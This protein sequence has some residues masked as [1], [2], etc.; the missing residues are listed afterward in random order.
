MVAYLLHYSKGSEFSVA[1][2]YIKHMSKKNRLIVLYGSC[3]GYHRIG[4]TAEMEEFSQKSPL[5]NVSFIPVKPSFKSKNWDY[6]LKGIREFY[7]EYEQW[8]KDLLQVVCQILQ[9]KKVDIIHFLGPIGY[10]EPGYLYD[11]PV[12]YI[13]G[14]IGGLV[15]APFRLLLVSDYK[16][17]MFGGLSLIVKSLTSFVRLWT[18]QR[19]KKAM[20]NADVV[21][22]AT[23]GYV[24]SIERA[25][26][27]NHHSRI[28][29]LPENC[30]EKVYELNLKKFDSEKIN[31]IYIGRLD[32]GKAPFLIL[33]AI[34]RLG[35]RA[36]KLHVD[37]LGGGP[38]EEMAKKYVE[39]QHLEDVVRFCGK[40]D[41]SIVL[42]MLDNAQLM[43][44]PSLYDAN[45]TVVWEAMSHAVPT[46]ALDHCGMHD[47]IK[48]DCG[49]KIPLG[50]Y[51]NVVNR[52]ATSLNEI[53][54]NPI[55]LRNMAE[56]LVIERMEYTWEKR[57]ERFESFYQIAEQ[58]FKNRL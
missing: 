47:T 52:I 12:P 55:V 41:R 4:N 50:S 43:L 6:S 15:K 36:N 17:K 2:D 5:E 29:Y 3:G 11:M 49:I 53:V 51:R 56:R 8:H 9:E 40:V 7:R 58:Q 24:N 1:W 38:L 35:D 39:E 33:E 26:G 16:T 30:I 27:R 57:A 21:I 22:G 48:E 54:S 28:C 31:L 45:T 32:E 14:P 23:T 25:I 10:H 42:D 37:M 34:A 18:N 13:W 44:L 20:R 19:V 46:L